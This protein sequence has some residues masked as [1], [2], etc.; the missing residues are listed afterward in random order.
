MV[1]LFVLQKTT[2]MFQLSLPYPILF[3]YNAIYLISSSHLVW[4]YMCNTTGTPCGAASAYPS[5]L[6]ETIFCLKRVTSCSVFN[7]LY[8]IFYTVV[9]VLI[10]F[11]WH[12]VVRLLLTFKEASLGGLSI[13]HR[14]NKFQHHTVDTIVYPE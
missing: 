10:F 7:C 6:Q 13:S 14:H 12:W 4:R 1:N 2:G 11:F 8:G 5:K 3:V 9:C